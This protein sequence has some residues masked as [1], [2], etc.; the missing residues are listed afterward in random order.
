MQKVGRQLNCFRGRSNLDRRSVITKRPP[1]WL[2]TR[3]PQFVQLNTTDS[4]GATPQLDPFS[5]S[6]IWRLDGRLHRLDG[7][8][9]ILN[10]GS[11]IWYRGGAV[12]RDED[13]PAS[14]RIN[15]TGLDQEWW[16]HGQKHREDAPAKVYEDGR[17]KWYQNDDLHRIDGPA[18]MYPD[19]GEEWYQYH[20]L[21]RVGGPAVTTSDNTQ[22]WWLDGQRH[23]IDGPAVVYPD[24]TQEWWLHDQRLACNDTEWEHYQRGERFKEQFKAAPTAHQPLA[25]ALTPRRKR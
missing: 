19:G 13:L 7:P 23:R 21:H 12:H 6:I 20:K 17:L 22:E 8:A 18:I 16:L 5:Q 25:Q 1:A 24:G 10:D 11:E 3:H 14:T 2:A 15:D 4:S 9:R